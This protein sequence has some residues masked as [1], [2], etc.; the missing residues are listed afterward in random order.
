MD[1][2]INDK[3]RI[4]GAWK[5]INFLNTNGTIDHLGNAYEFYYTRNV[6]DAVSVKAG[7]YL[8]DPAYEDGNGTSIKNG[9][10]GDDWLLYEETAYAFETIFRF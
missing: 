7:V 4:S 5:N 10:T 6:N 1:Y 2:E 9:G 3:N 8:V